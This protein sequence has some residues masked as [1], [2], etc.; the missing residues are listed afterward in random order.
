MRDTLPAL[1]LGDSSRHVPSLSGGKDSTAMLLR[2]LA[3]GY[4]V[5]EIVFFDTGWE[6]PQ[7]LEH[8]DLLEKRIGRKI[9]RLHPKKSFDWWMTERP[10]KSRKT[11]KVHRIGYGWP[12]AY[13]RWCTRL[14]INSIDAYLSKDDVRYIGYSADEAHR[15]NT[16]S[17]LRKPYKCKYPLYNWDMSESDCLEYCLERGYNWGGLYGIF[18]RVSCYCC[19]MQRVG[20]LKKLRKHFPELWTKML[21][22]EDRIQYPEGIQPGFKDYTAL[23]DYEIRFNEEDKQMELPL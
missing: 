3:G 23:H 1:V 10:I 20:K 16:A 9:T 4:P 14:K 21:D 2:L 7:M 13:R 12:S 5:D 17:I 8:I 19:P 18:N 6:F 11:K 22:M 15:M